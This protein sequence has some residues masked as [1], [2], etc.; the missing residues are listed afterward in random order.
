MRDL[1][2][3]L[4]LGKRQFATNMIQ[5]PLAGI[6][7][8]PFRRL[9]WQYS[10]PAFSFTEM[11]SCKTLLYSPKHLSERF[12]YKAKE[13]GALAFQL[14]SSE[15]LEL[16]EAVKRVTD[17]G[18]DVINLNCGCPV[19]K[20][21]RK[22]A[23]SRLL[24]KPI[25][26]SRLIC[27]MKVNTHLPVSIKI[28]VDG[29]SHEHFNPEIIKVVNDSGLDFII[30]HG[31]HWTEGYD[32]SCRYEEI[33]DFVDQLKIPVIGNGDVACRISLGKMFATGCAGVMIGRAGMGQP[34]LI[35]KLIHE[36]RGEPFIPPALSA[37]G[38]LFI[39]HI[40]HLARLL[41]NETFALMNARKF[42]KYYAREMTNKSEF[43][44]AVTAC[45]SLQAF[46]VVCARYFL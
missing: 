45:D 7:T 39:E 5:G 6:S 28:R 25:E 19:K 11:I 16:G 43:C 44:E 24:A 9:I 29:N 3:P 27:S 46:E 12:T 23:G 36:I 15:P 20:I 2:H 42:A 18:A 10:Q 13:E 26:L 33:R 21:R 30:V 22:G 17:L 37:I 41:R 14:S 35:D 8:A 38:Q 34:W 32:V 1:I 40:L 31:R 4:R